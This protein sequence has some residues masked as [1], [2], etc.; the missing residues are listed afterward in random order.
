M[1]DN[2]KALTCGYIQDTIN[3]Q[4]KYLYS[5]VRV[6]SLLLDRYVCL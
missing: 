1:H 3:T 2:C 4:L 6:M 5:G